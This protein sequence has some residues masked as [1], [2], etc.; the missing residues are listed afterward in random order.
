MRS[1][2]LSTVSKEGEERKE[3]MQKIEKF[4]KGLKVE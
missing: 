2:A 4:L 3:I 1:L